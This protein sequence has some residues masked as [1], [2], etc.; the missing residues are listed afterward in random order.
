[1]V[2]WEIENY[3]LRKRGGNFLKL[4]DYVSLD[5]KYECLKYV[6]TEQVF[7]LASILKIRVYT[8]HREIILSVL[9]VS[10]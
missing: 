2:H 7:K 6:K 8:F 5:T 1:M 9:P 10:I 3:S 4:C